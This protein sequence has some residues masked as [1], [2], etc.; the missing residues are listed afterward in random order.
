MENGDRGVIHQISASKGGVPKLPIRRAVV[1][2]RG[3]TVDAQ[4]DVKNHGHPHQA[5]C[6]WSL[7][8]IER[9]QGEGHNVFPGA[10]GENITIEGLDWERVVPGSRLRLGREVVIE[11]TGYTTPC[12]KNAQWFRDGDMNR[13]NQKTHPGESRVYARVLHGGEIVMGDPVQLLPATARERAL[14]QQPATFRWPRD[15]Q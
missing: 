14:R 13:M 4:A 11:V 2:E 6:L 7:E 12:W 15:F 5:L 9:M 3:I 10:T 1:M 8:V